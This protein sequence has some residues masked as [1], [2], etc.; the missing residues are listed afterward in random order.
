MK[1]A[2]GCDHGGYALKLAVKKHR[3]RLWKHKIWQQP[4]KNYGRGAGVTLG[5]PPF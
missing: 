1:I 3:I 4:C 2:I 5:R